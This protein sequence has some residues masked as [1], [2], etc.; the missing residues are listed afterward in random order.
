MAVVHEEYIGHTH[1][2]ICDDYCKDVTPEQV[3][4]I[5]DRIAMRALAAIRAAAGNDENP[6]DVAQSG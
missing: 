3:Q 6:Q 4:A 5:L 1:I 2:L